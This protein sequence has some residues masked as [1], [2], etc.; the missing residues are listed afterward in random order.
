MTTKRKR[1]TNFNECRFGLRYLSTL[2]T[3]G[4]GGMA[5]HFGDQLHT[6]KFGKNI[7]Y[8]YLLYLETFA[9]FLSSLKKRNIHIRRDAFKSFRLFHCFVFLREWLLGYFPLNSLILK[10]KKWPKS[11][12]NIQNPHRTI[13]CRKM[14]SQ[15]I[16]REVKHF[17]NSYFNWAC[18]HGFSI[19][20]F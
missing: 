3:R 13:L 14:H 19:E 6:R 5:P 15:Y 9:S 4:K 16:V 8:I 20:N 12:K 18:F 7:T 1:W 11:L 2:S 17:L 10:A